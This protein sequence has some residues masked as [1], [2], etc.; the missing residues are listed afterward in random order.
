MFSTSSFLPAQTG[1]A[2]QAKVMT[3]IKPIHPILLS[4]EPI[5]L[6]SFANNCWD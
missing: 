3:R 2:I 5:M 6:T 1:A 4:F